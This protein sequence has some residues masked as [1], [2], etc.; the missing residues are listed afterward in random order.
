MRMFDFEDLRMIVMDTSLQCAYPIMF[1]AVLDAYQEEV[2]EITPAGHW[3]R[4]EP[5]GRD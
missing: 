2:K 4:P 3:R 1:L 5:N